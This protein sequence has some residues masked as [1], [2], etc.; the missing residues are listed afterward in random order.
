MITYTSLHFP[1]TIYG[2]H[3]WQINMY[4]CILYNQLQATSKLHIW[5]LLQKNICTCNVGKPCSPYKC[6]QDCKIHI[7]GR[8]LYLRG[9]L[10]SQV[11]RYLGFKV[12]YYFYYNICPCICIYAKTSFADVAVSFSFFYCTYI[13]ISSYK[14]K[15][16]DTEYFS[17]L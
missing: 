10:Y 12:Y 9:H 7:S 16:C 6:C 1:K 8:T 17:N 15:Y 3:S 4:P 13:V 11:F 5:L 14:V 2:L